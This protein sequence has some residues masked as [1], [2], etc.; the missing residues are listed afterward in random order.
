MNIPFTNCSIRTA[1]SLKKRLDDAYKRYKEGELLYLEDYY[2]CIGIYD[3]RM[4]GLC[5]Y[6]NNR[7]LFNIK[8]KR[9]QITDD[10]ILKY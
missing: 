7:D 1:K 3:A 2:Y 4:F 10:N 9:V 8:I 6:R 5:F